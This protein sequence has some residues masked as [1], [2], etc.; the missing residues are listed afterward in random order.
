MAGK[1]GGGLLWVFSLPIVAGTLALGLLTHTF[2]YLIGQD[3]S[4]SVGLAQSH[5]GGRS[6]LP[7][8]PHSSP[9]VHCGVTGLLMS[10]LSRDLGGLLDVGQIRETTAFRNP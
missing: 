7:R 4:L 6:L 10:P 1:V 2:F 9:R 3:E 5:F 8:P